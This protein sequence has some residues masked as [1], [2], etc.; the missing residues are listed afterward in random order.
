MAVKT[1]PPQ[2]I[3][4]WSGRSGLTPAASYSISDHMLA[5]YKAEHPADT[6]S[7]LSDYIARYGY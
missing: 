1:S 5:A 2:L 4:N 6:F 7:S 3:P